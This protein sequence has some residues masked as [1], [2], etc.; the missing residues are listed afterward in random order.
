MNYAGGGTL[1]FSNSVVC[2]SHLLYWDG[3]LTAM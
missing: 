1:T 2:V 3:D